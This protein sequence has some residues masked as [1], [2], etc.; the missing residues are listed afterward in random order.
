MLHQTIFITKPHR[1]VGLK[2]I[3]DQLQHFW[4]RFAKIAAGGQRTRQTIQSRGAFF[5]AAL[6]LFAFVQLGRQMSDDN[7]DDEVSAEHHEVFEFADVKRE[8]W[9]NEQKVPEQRAKCSQEKCGPATQSH[10]SDYDCEQIEERDCP[11]TN[12]IKD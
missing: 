12:V 2:K 10:S 8:A 6:G 5:P 11:I 1:C 9:R 7:S 4:K 3:S